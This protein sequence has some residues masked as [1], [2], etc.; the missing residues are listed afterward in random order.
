MRNVEVNCCIA[1]LYLESKCSECLV[2]S[3]LLYSELT[4]TGLPFS[5][6]PSTILAFSTPKHHTRALRIRRRPT[7]N[8]RARQL[9]LKL[10]SG[11]ENSCNLW[12][13]CSDLYDLDSNQSWNQTL[14]MGRRKALGTCL[15]NFQWLP[16][17][18]IMCGDT[19]RTLIIDLPSQKLG[20]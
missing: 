8:T 1:T 14:R 18:V 15:R 17:N 4:T 5:V 7:Y 12:L 20:G 19:T 10:G 2:G 3:L 16:Q 11:F 13:N 6:L 9:T